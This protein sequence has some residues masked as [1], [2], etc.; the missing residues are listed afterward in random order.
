MGLSALSIK[1]NELD[2]AKFARKWFQR[3]L[4][5]EPMRFFFLPR[6]VAEEDWEN[7]GIDGGVVFDRCR[8]VSCLRDL[9]RDLLLRCKRTTKALLKDLRQAA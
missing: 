3:S 1:L 6:N 8:I 2:G 5:V 7:I 4:V 9:D